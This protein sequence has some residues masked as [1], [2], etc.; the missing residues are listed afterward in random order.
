MINTASILRFPVAGTLYPNAESS[1]LFYPNSQTTTLKIRRVLATLTLHSNRA[2]T[3]WNASQK[4][5]LNQISPDKYER[6]ICL[7]YHLILN[8]STLSDCHDLL[9]IRRILT[10][11]LSFTQL[12]K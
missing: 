8:L 6:L 5:G 7:F 3:D 10:H 1:R 11:L 2:K 9:Y 12:S 4:L